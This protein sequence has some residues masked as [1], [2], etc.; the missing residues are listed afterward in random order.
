MTTTQQRTL[1][2]VQVF[3]KIQKTVIYRLNYYVSSVSQLKR[4][5]L[6]RKTYS[7]GRRYGK[8]VSHYN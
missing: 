2:M 4:V 6:Y 8:T 1:L 5:P 7:L 3:T